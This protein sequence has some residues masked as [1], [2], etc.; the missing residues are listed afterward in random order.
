MRRR[1]EF[2]LR[3]ISIKISH[4]NFGFVILFPMEVLPNGTKHGTTCCAILGL[5]LPKQILLLLLLIMILIASSA[6]VP[7]V[8]TDETTTSNPMMSPNPSAEQ[9]TIVAAVSPPSEATTAPMKSSTSQPTTQASLVATASATALGCWDDGG[10]IEIDI[11]ETNLLRLPLE[12]RVYLPPCYHQEFERHYPVLFLIHGQS[13][14]DDQWDRLGAD[15]TADRLIADGKL[16]PFIIVMPRDRFGGQPR[17]NN[18]ARVIVE[19][20]LEYIDGE[21]RTRPERQYR[22]VGGL[23]RGGGWAV[24]LGLNHWDTF[25]AFG[26]H[27]PA[28]FFDDA[29][30][31]RVYL[32]EIPPEAMPRIYL[33]IGDRDRPEIMRA[34]L[35]FE[36]L[37]NVFGISHEWYLFSGY[38]TEEYWQDHLETYLL[39]YADNW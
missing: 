38:H 2:I 28:I 33:D 24:H 29:Q 37:L 34:A 21:Y 18:F 7:V 25:G 23:S 31:M 13:Y 39:W 3:R 20:L 12:Y 6:C 17:E 16:A 9:S 11:L 19:E 1:D 32:G 22:A 27:S 10:N 26:G 15:E 36:E 5:G 4:L 14:N 35:W 30:H 8:V